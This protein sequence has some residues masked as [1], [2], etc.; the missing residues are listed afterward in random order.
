MNTPCFIHPLSH[1]RAFELPP[2]F[3]FVNSTAVSTLTHASVVHMH[4]FFSA[5][6]LGGQPPPN[7][8]VWILSALGPTLMW[9]PGEEH[10]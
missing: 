8:F 1:R 5:T 7:S 4:E 6:D 3:A 2:G 9:G 10:C